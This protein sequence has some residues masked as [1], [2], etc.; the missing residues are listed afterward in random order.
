MSS[1]STLLL[2]L[3]KNKA[4]LTELKEA[5]NRSINVIGRDLESLSERLERL[6]NKLDER[7]SVE[8]EREKTV[9]E[10][11][12]TV[13]NLEREKSQAETKL[14]TLKETESQLNEQLKELESELIKVQDNITKMK[15]SISKLT[16]ACK[17][18][19]DEIVRLENEI[20]DIKKEHDKA[21]ASL[22]SSYE[23]ESN[24]LNELKAKYSAL[25]FLIKKK[26]L[27]IPELKVI[28]VIKDQKTTT[29][30]FIERSTS[31]KTSFIQHVVKG[32]ADRGVI[33]YNASTGEIKTL[34]EIEI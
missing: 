27:E 22:R 24:R 2:S 15:D 3:K 7:Q 4:T 29:I 21:I 25:K 12:A 9:S 23:K 11:E 13:S 31:L 1:V 33:E 20:E 14:S 5:F 19:E 16:Q 26:I 8:E 28:Q 6:K 17:E 18:K 10:L 34:R 30:S 32:L